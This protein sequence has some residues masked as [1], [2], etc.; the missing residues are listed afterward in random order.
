MSK[1]SKQKAAVA[2][3]ATPADDAPIRRDTM[4]RGRRWT[5]IV[6]AI[7]CLLIFSVTGPMADAFFRWFAPGGV[8]VTATLNLPSGPAEITV[9]DYQSAL[10]MLD[11]EA[12]MN[13]TRPDQEFEQVLVT[14][15]LMRLADEFQVQ[16]SEQE[17][18][19]LL[20]P[21]AQRS[22]T[23]Y[24]DFYRR[25]GFLRASDFESM[26]ARWMR[27]QRVRELLGASVV[28]SDEEVL[29]AWQNLYQEMNYGYALWHPAEF[30]DAA[31]E[32]TPTE[33]VL[34]TFFDAGLTPVQKSGLEREQAVAFELLAVDAAALAQPQVQAL[35]GSDAQP[36]QPALEG[37]YNRYSLSL[38]RRPALAA[39]ETRP[40]GQGEV[41]PIAELG[42]RLLRDY[43][44]H[45]AL[46]QA[47]LSLPGVTDAAAFAAQNGLRLEAFAETVGLSE[48][49]KLPVYGSFQL[50]NLFSGEAGV[51]LQSPVLLPDGVAYLARPTK[52]QQRE[53]PP[54]AEVRDPVI[55]HW[56]EQ[57]QTRL[58][59]E[60]AEAFVAS[61]PHQEGW[62]EGDPVTLASAGFSQA[63]GAERRAEIRV[64]WIARTVRPATDPIWGS[65]ETAQRRARSLL[66]TRLKDLVDG[67]VIGTEDFGADGIAVLHLDG[68]RAAD[69]AKIWPNELDRARADAQR[70]AQMNFEAEQISF[71]GFAKS[72]GL[73]RVLQEAVN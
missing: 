63:L 3:P 51:W 4:S 1:S 68:R 16:T 43:Q 72:Y 73:T 60:A 9:E 5:L 35:L 36:S 44:L 19:E 38:Y 31:A 10:S 25:L 70:Q 14:A 45:A 6:I 8:N 2:R 46:I 62:V 26:L 28:V 21:L 41:F 64:D 30:A 65:E 47:G 57:E 53:M 66:G 22:A 27:L 11:F 59:R 23:G 17:L 29:Q 55:G 39:G 50:R 56:R 12:R 20:L 61:L 15:T 34:Q 32:L 13:G 52:I 49:E 71:A 24:S 18:R 58:A 48:L 7:F 67:Q 37:F 42:D 54:L 33:E 40:E 69:A